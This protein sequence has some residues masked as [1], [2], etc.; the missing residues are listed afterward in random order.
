VLSFALLNCAVMSGPHQSQ[1]C[2]P[3]S[4]VV[5]YSLVVVLVLNIAR[6][7]VKHMYDLVRSFWECT[8]A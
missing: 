8:R 4:N 7:M 5:I 2:I 3:F 1:F 6:C